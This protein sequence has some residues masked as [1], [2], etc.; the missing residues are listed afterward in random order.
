MA[1]TR[2]KTDN[3]PGELKSNGHRKKVFWFNVIFYAILFGGIIL[4]S[5]SSL[6]LIIVITLIAFAASILY[7]YLY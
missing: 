2:P 3:S 5:F 7:T 1:N 6:A 4:V